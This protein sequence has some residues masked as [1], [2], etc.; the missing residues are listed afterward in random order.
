MLFSSGAGGERFDADGWLDTGDVGAMHRDGFL[1][2]AGRDGE[3]I[4]RGGEKVFPREVHPRMPHGALGLADAA[5]G[6]TRT[7]QAASSSAS[8]STKT[9]RA[10]TTRRS[11]LHTLPHVT[12]APSVQCPPGRRSAKRRSR[13]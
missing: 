1:T 13:R 11:R 5:S 6:R 4:N 9:W 10:P 3:V 12:I 2:L 8:A 7:E